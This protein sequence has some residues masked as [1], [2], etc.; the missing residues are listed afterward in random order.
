FVREHAR[1]YLH[2]ETAEWSSMFDTPEQFEEEL[3]TCLRA[4]DRIPDTSPDDFELNEEWGRLLGQAHVKVGDYGPEP[5]GNLSYCG[6][7]GRHE[8]PWSEEDRAPCGM[9]SAKTI[10]T[11]AFGDGPDDLRRYMEGVRGPSHE[12]RQSVCACG[13][14]TFRL[15]LGTGEYA[16]AVRRT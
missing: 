10:A 13:N 16:E 2:C 8:V 9:M 7:P 14:V 4:F 3:R 15:Q 5:L 1:D 11:A 12:Y 6:L